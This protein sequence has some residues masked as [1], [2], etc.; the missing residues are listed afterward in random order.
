MRLLGVW[1]LALVGGLLFPLRRAAA[2][3]IAADKLPEAPLAAAGTVRRAT[4]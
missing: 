3:P 2:E 4:I 1:S